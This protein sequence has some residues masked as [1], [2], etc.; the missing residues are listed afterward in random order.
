M[1]TA[2]SPFGHFLQRASV[3][4]HRW[5]DVHAA[6][7]V[8][9]STYSSLY[10]F[11]LFDASTESFDRALALLHVDRPMRLTESTSAQPIHDGFITLLEL[12]E[13]ASGT[14]VTPALRDFMLRERKRDA[15]DHLRACYGRD[16]PDLEEHIVFRLMDYSVFDQGTAHVG[17][18]LMTTRDRTWRNWFWSRVVFSHK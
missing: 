7:H 2:S 14:L 15:E 6:L 9:H 17:F 8:D 18:G 5:F 16:R 4:P 12:V 11:V 13:D 1:F 3:E 10:D